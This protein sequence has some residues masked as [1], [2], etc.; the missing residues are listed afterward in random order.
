MI[1]FSESQ[2]RIIARGLTILS[3]AVVLVFVAILALGFFK[4]LT[5]VSS[6]LVPVIFGFF[7]ALFFRPYYRWWKRLLRNPTLAVILML[8]TVLVPLGLLL[9]YAGAVV[10]DQ[11]T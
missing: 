6:A 10:I 2:K 4:V 1:E 7:L 3:L 11:V 8:L 5:L 9:W